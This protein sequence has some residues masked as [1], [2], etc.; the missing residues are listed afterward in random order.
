[1]PYLDKDRQR[2]FQR[3][4]LR[5]RRDAWIRENGPCIDCGS[6]DRLEVDHIDPEQKISH[7]VWSWSKKRRDDELKK[8][9][10]RCKKHH[11]VKTMLDQH[12]PRWHGTSRMYSTGCRCTNCSKAIWQY[13]CDVVRSDEVFL[14]LCNFGLTP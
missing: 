6:S 12:G 11:Q 2:Q 9:V 3:D 7:R 8:C 14:P 13:M 4:W 10:V 1:M 5:E